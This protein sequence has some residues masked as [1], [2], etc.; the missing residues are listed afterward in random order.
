MK[1]VL[2]PKMPIRFGVFELEPQTGE[3][4]KQGVKIRLQE[5]PFQILQVLLEQPGK[6]VTREE[7]RQRSGR[8]IHS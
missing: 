1:D 7:L 8:P 6:V 2:P 3:L 5:Q 4:R